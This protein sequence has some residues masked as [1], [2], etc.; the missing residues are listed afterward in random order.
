MKQHLADGF[1]SASL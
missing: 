1:Q